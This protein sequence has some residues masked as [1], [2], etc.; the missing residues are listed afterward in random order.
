MPRSTLAVTSQPSDKGSF[1]MAIDNDKL[2]EFL[3]KFVTD[4]GATVAAGNVVIG[5]NLGLYKT[6]VR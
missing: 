3:G 5:H 2:N 6:L 1:I 4:L